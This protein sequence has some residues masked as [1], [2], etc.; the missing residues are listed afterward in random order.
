MSTVQTYVVDDYL[1]NY[2]YF[3]TH[4]LDDRALYRKSVFRRSLERRSAL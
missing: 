4:L 1:L 3:D 2:L